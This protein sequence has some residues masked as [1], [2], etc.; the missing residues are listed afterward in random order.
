M[1]R[2]LE[3][4]AGAVLV[5]VTAAGAS[6]ADDGTV[7]GPDLTDQREQLVEDVLRRR[8]TAFLLGDETGWLAD[9]DSAAAGYERVRFR[10]LRQLRP[11]FFRLLTAGGDM[12][13]TSPEPAGGQV[14][15]RQVLRLPGERANVLNTHTWRI[16]FRDGRA[17]ITAV[18]AYVLTGV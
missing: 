18:R 15:V 7:V 12:V 2:W 5:A 9:V 13:G 8:T 1:Q 17:M 3:S 16:T 4:V 10:N 11:T 14:H 6:T